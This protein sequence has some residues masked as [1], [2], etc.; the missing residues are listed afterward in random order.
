MFAWEEQGSLFASG[1]QNWFSG[2]LHTTQHWVEINPNN[3]TLGA[4]YVKTL[5]M[6]HPQH[7]LVYPEEH[8]TRIQYPIVHWQ[9]HT[10]NTALLPEWEASYV[11]K[12]K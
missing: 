3:L 11:P 10:G 8:P 5:T 12:E 9:T 7:Q 2:E 1:T 6:L 4:R